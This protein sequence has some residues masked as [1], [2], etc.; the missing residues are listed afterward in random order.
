MSYPRWQG[1]FPAATTQL[2]EDQSIDWKAQATHLEAL[3]DSGIH[4]L[5][6]CGSLGENQTLSPEEKREVVKHAIEVSAGRV[7][8]LSGVAEMS[9][10]AASQYVQDLESMGAAGAMVLPAMVYKADPRE[11]MYHFRT[12]AAASKLPIIVYNNPVGY[13]VDITPKMLAELAEVENLVAIK[14]SSADTTRIT[15]LYNACGDRY[16]IFG[17]VDTLI[18][19][20]V[21]LGATGW[22]AGVGLAFPKENAYLWDLMTAGEWDKVRAMWRWFLPLMTLDIGPHFVQKI[23]LVIQEAGLGNEWVRAPRLTLTGAEREETLALIHHGLANR[24]K[25]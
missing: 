23:K 14:E 22:I 4:G 11:T 8:V 10:A 12:V 18:P 21:L 9:T 15:E 6:M 13:Y 24:P 25:L 16:A 2:F 19:E 17:G 7:P 3:I 5:I 20:S 1:V